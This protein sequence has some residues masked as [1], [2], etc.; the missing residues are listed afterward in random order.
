MAKPKSKGDDA[1]AGDDSDR[2]VIEMECP[3]LIGRLFHETQPDGSIKTF[4]AVPGGAI[5]V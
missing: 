2:K 4:Q 1:E 3:V 5:E